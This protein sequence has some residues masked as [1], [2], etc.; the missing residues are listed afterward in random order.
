RDPARTVRA[1]APG[2]GRAGALRLPAGDRG[3]G[4]DPG[5]GPGRADRRIS[6]PA[7]PRTARPRRHRAPDAA[8]GG[9][10]GTGVGTAAAPAHAAAGGPA[11][12]GV[13]AAARPPAAAASGRALR[14]RGPGAPR[15]GRAA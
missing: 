12:V 8:R 14:G 1:R 10:L 4:G 2:G 15:P 11:V 3:G 6:P 7:R 5:G 13:P 9:A